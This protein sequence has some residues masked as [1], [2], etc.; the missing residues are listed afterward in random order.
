MK[1]YFFILRSSKY[2]IW[3]KKILCNLN[4]DVLLY[5]NQNLY[6]Y[7]WQLF[8][9]LY[10]WPLCPV[11]LL[12]PLHQ[13]SDSEDE[14]KIRQ[15]EGRAMRNMKSKSRSAPYKVPNQK[16]AYSNQFQRQ[17]FCAGG[18]RRQPG[19]WDICFLC[20]QQ[21]H[22]RKNCPLNKWGAFGGAVV[23]TQQDTMVRSRETE[24]VVNDKYT[25]FDFCTI[26]YQNS[27]Y[28]EFF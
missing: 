27:D 20:K 28:I 11:V 25:D 1:I 26:E 8:L 15:A 21:G 10:F 3:L 14:K 5:K 17:P 12:P 16:P 19:T 22:W 23:A 6:T 24:T 7:H 2:W 13:R 4:S 18:A 9:F